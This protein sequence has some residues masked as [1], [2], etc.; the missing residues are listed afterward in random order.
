MKTLHT[1]SAKCDENGTPAPTDNRLAVTQA[2]TGFWRRIRATANGLVF[3]SSSNVQVFVTHDE[4]WKLVEAN[5]PRL[6]QPK[7]N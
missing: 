5:E 7:R 6:A 2:Q 3:E 1:F 4:L